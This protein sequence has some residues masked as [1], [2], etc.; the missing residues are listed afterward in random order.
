MRHMPRAPHEC[1]NVL[2]IDLEMKSKEGKAAPGVD[3]L[4]AKVAG[5]RTEERKKEAS[6]HT[7]RGDH[8][9]SE[10]DRKAIDDLRSILEKRR[11]GKPPSPTE[12]TPPKI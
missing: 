2:W 5:L 3:A 9:L 4:E 8:D 7:L 10:G 11:E 1:T 6:F 12:G